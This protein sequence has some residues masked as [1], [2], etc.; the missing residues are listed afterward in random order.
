VLVDARHEDFFQRMPSAYLQV[1]ETNLQRVRWLRIITPLGF[2]RLAGNAGLL[3]SFESYLDPLPAPQLSAAIAMMFYQPRHW[4]TS[5]AE[6]EVILDSFAEVR[7]IHLPADLPLVVLTASEGVDAWRSSDNPVDQAT[8]DRWMALQQ[9]LAGLSTRSQWII[10]QKS[11]HYIFLDQPQAV[12]DAIRSLLS[13]T[14]HN[15]QPLR[16]F[17][18]ARF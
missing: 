2:T 1:D 13:R 18:P 11:G 9:E 10:V 4:Q 8:R 17:A 15:G 16:P 6:R 3:T 5:I 14:A 7:G 12:V